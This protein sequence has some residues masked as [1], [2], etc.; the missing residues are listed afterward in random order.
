MAHTYFVDQIHKIS[1]SLAG[2]SMKAK[3][4][5]MADTQDKPVPSSS[6]LS[7]RKERGLSQTES[8]PSLGF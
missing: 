7:L 4:A 8:K 3:Q 6:Q 2:G 5:N 1:V